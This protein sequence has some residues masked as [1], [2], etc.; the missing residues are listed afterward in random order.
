MCEFFVGMGY[1]WFSRKDFTK[2]LRNY[3]KSD[4]NKYKTAGD[5]L[6]ILKE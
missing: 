3:S 1:R 4:R 5:Y 2:F 6:K